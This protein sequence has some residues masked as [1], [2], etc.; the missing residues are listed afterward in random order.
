MPT[1]VLDLPKTHTVNYSSKPLNGNDEIIEISPQEFAHQ[2]NFE[3]HDDLLIEDTWVESYQKQQKEL[4]TLACG[5]ALYA[6]LYPQEPID[7]SVILRQM[8]FL[9]GV[10]KQQQQLAEKYLKEIETIIPN[11]VVC[12]INDQVGKGL[13]WRGPEVLKKGTAIACYAGVMD[14]SLPG[15]DTFSGYGYTVPAHPLFKNHSPGARGVINGF[16]GNHARFIQHF[17]D[18]ENFSQ[19]FKLDP[20]LQEQDIATAN[21]EALNIVYDG[22]PLVVLVTTEDVLPNSQFGFDYGASYWAKAYQHCQIEPLLFTRHSETLDPKTYERLDLNLILG[23]EAVSLPLINIMKCILANQPYTLMDTNTKDIIELS[24]AKLT[25]MVVEEL[26]KKNAAPNTIAFHFLNWLL[27]IKEAQN[28]DGNYQSKFINTIH[29]ILLK[30]WLQNSF[31]HSISA[32]T[33]IPYIDK[34]MSAITESMTADQVFVEVRTKLNFTS[35]RDFYTKQ[36]REMRSEMISAMK[37]Y[38]EDKVASRN[39]LTEAKGF[40]L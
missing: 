40:V 30:H 34:V 24:P 39:T 16:Q 13:F 36:L 35:D 2:F 11:L 4:H 29:S 28:S 25:T 23:R 27:R 9:P 7:E 37:T 38:N 5:Y 17:P 21:V 1:K 8:P 19:R 14:A 32:K 6:D 15:T 26:K 10:I 22:M 18:A 31:D 3:W 20:G 12:E 33:K